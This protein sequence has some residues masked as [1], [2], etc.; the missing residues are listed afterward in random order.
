M[1]IKQVLKRFE[2]ELTKSLEDWVDYASKF[3]V[4]ISAAP[5]VLPID[6][7]RVLLQVNDRID[8]FRGELKS[9]Y[10]FYKKL[11]HDYGLNPLSVAYLEQYSILTQSIADS[12]ARVQDVATKYESIL[13]IA[14]IASIN[15]N[16][17]VTI[18]N[19]KAI[20]RVLTLD[21]AELLDMLSDND[22]LGF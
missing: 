18:H 17:Y 19:Q 6:I 3:H 14:K 9:I 13:K 15:V 1:E 7:Y 22:L 2:R 21:V 11:E 8:A 5:Q 10:K 16:T 20:E 12:L 4:S